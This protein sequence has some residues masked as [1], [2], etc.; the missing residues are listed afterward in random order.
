MTFE[1]FLGRAQETNPALTREPQT[2]VKV[3]VAL[4]RT[5]LRQAF[6]AGQKSS[7]SE[8]S[9]FEHVFGRKG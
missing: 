8:K 1:T 6:E 7:R 4:V 3:R 2:K 5:L 9:I